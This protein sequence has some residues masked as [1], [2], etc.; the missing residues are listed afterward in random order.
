MSSDLFRLATIDFETDP[1]RKGRIPLP[2]LSGFY[3]GDHLLQ[4]WGKNCVAELVEAIDALGPRYL[5]F[6]H[7]GGRYDFHMMLPY[8]DNPIKIISGRIVRARFGPIGSE[9]R[10]YLQ[11]SYAIIPAPLHK[12]GGKMDV[13]EE[14]YKLFE[15]G[16]RERHRKKILAYH[17]QD[18]VTLHDKVGRF[19]DLFGRRLTIGGTGMRELQK[20]YPF[21]KMG[22]GADAFYR[23]FYYGGRVQCFS[24]GDHRAQPGRDFK[25][26][27][28]NSMYPAVMRNYR[29][30]INAA[31]DRTT[32]LPDDPDKVYFAI[33]DATSKGALPMRN[34]MGGIDFPDARGI[35]RAC[36][37]EIRSAQRHGLLTIHG[38]QT[39]HVA[40][41]TTTFDKFVDFVFAKRLAAKVANDHVEDQLFKYA[42]NACYGK[43]GQD[44]ENFFDWSISWEIGD[45]SPAADGWELYSTCNDFD[46]WR[47]PAQN[48]QGAY[49]DVS[50]AAS[51]TSAARATLLD[52]LQVARRPL[53]C[54]TDSII[55]EGFDGD[56]DATR[57][58]AWK[59]EETADRVVIAGK[60]L[61]AL[62]RGRKWIKVRSKG[63]TL[64]GPDIVKI[65][66]GEL[67]VYERDVPI[68]SSQFLGTAKDKRRFPTRTFRRT[69]EF[70]A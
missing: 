58:G 28:V 56:V 16:V 26:Y 63:G 64:T 5:I 52:A 57:L 62:Q 15:R 27:D 11:D 49:N 69:A 14:F 21:L 37:H 53:Y 60:K 35:F 67:F 30:P 42:G 24:A 51:I 8:I 47:R 39:C 61:Y 65:T 17:A 55:C 4:F 48:M 9:N 20:F 32:D 23:S 10:H 2:F 66:R 34:A 29:H 3:D 12:L 36:S 6:A 13:D 22:A 40:Q 7:N 33:I 38:V 18:L 70:P 41:M 25:V 45:N 68:F 44:P 1:F 19:H 46:L 54:D 59:E 43:F 50:V 31:F